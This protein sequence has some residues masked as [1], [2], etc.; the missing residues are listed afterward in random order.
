MLMPSIF[1][2]NFIDRFFEDPFE[3]VPYEGTELMK[4]DI[5]DMGSGY[6]VTMN[7]PGVM[8]E[9]VKAEL[10]DGY[11]TVSASSN[12]HKEEKDETGRYIPVSYTHL[13]VYKRQHLFCFRGEKTRL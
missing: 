13:D 6:E 11:L 1:G 10:K 12:S 3:F 5:K 4:T 9:D 8:K 7:L 2:E